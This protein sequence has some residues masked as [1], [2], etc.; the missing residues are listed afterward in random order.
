[1]KVLPLLPPVISLILVGGWVTYRRQSISTLEGSSAALQKQWVVAP[2]QLTRSAAQAS[3]VNAQEPLVGKKDPLKPSGKVPTGG[4]GDLAA[5]SKEELVAALDA[6]PSLNLSAETRAAREHELLYALEAKDLELSLNRYAALLQG[7]SRSGMAHR[8]CTALQEWL[9]KDPAKA[10][11][12]ADQQIAA[13][14][15]DGKS[16]DGEN[17]TL[18]M[19]EGA[20]IGALLR[21]DPA[22]AARRLSAVPE[23]Q[24][25][26][27]LAPSSL[28][29]IKEENQ[30]ALAMLVRSQT[31][32]GDQTQLIARQ[33]IYMVDDSGYGKV[34]E[35]MDR[36]AA[37]PAE[38]LACIEEAANY[39]IRQIS[40]RGK[41][42]REDLDKMR[43]W[44]TSQAPGSTE[45][46]T[47][48][49]LANSLPTSS[50]QD[51]ATAAE[52]VLLYHSTNGNDDVITSFLEGR[53]S[54]RN[55]DDARALAGKINDPKVRE[56]FLKKFQ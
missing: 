4:K 3:T 20:L 43:E 6:I 40:I 11:A 54:A 8:L 25:A 16:L 31:S 30:L 42:T 47:G 33:V 45:S 22:A 10:T 55:K 49:A 27:I 1:M 38:R 17:P 21:S 26:K 41:V 13:G 44:A 28:R 46:I 53:D 15:F 9:E 18:N 52:W 32:G 23:D 29:Y 36:I 5:M 19:V 34:S 7:D 24:R 51:F 14:T 56:E 12:W 39:G 2:P 50:Q 37:T 35:Y 48:K